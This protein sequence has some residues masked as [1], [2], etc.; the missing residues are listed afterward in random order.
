MKEGDILEIPTDSGSKKAKLLFVS[1]R[2][3][4]AVLLDF[5]EFTLWTGNQKIKKKEWRISGNEPLTEKEKEAA[6][7]IVADSLVFRDEPIRIA[8]EED[9][10]KYPKM[11]VAGCA[12]V[13]R[14]ALNT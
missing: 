12:L 7:C 13:E 1:K 14:K 10:K 9:Q 8:T 6:Y 4:N 2:Y 11:Q 3:K 5:P